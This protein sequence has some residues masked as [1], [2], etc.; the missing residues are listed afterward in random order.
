[1]SPEVIKLIYPDVAVS[2]GSRTS[3]PAAAETTTV[4]EPVTIPHEYLEEVR[5]TRVEILHRSDRS[6]VTVLDLLSPTNKVA[7]GFH[8]Y[9]NKRKAILTQKIHLVELD[10]LIG[11]NRL[12]LL[13]PLPPGDYYA[14]VS[15][16]EKRPNYDVFAWTVRQPLPSLA[17]PLRAPDADIV[18]DLQAVLALTYQR[19]RYA[20]ALAYARPPLAP[21]D[22]PDLVWATQIAANRPT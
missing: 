5:E 11:G 21:L 19:G 10:L 4:L 16:V 9:R 6:L 20:R 2:R 1:M 7:D 13:R 18:L 17:I 12:P 14:L 8:E 22:E 3:R 15:R